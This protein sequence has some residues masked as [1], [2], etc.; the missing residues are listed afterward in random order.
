[1][2]ARAPGHGG[3]LGL[4]CFLTPACHAKGLG[5]GRRGE[6]SLQLGES[7]GVGEHVEGAGGNTRAEARGQGPEVVG[8]KVAHGDTRDGVGRP[9]RRRVVRSRI[10]GWRP[11]GGVQGG[12]IGVDGH[13]HLY[14]WPGMWRCGAGPFVST[15][16]VKSTMRW[17]RMPWFSPRAM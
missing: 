14:G 15:S 17:V 10:L 12:V 7:I 3:R 5:L 2:S 13:R 16:W 8:V 6:L 4:G 1:L 9:D 11:V